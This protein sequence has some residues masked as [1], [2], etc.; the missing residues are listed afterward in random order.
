MKEGRGIVKRV[1]K[2]TWM[3]LVGTVAAFALAGAAAATVTFDFGTGTGFV[4][5]GDV[6][7]AFGWNNA[8]LQAN[9]AS[10]SFYTQEID[11]WYQ[12]CVTN[13]GH[14]EFTVVGARIQRQRQVNDQV[15]YDTRTNRRADVTGFILT[16]YGL[17]TRSPIPDAH[18]QCTD[19]NPDSHPKGEPY[20]VDGTPS[21]YVGYGG[22]SVKLA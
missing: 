12:D 17:E 9:A 6:Q 14:G 19:V 4:G 18:Q 20:E 16:G 3:L 11:T 22:N 5:K 13:D 8:A 21:L 2:K 15:Q 7:S 10:V 1:T